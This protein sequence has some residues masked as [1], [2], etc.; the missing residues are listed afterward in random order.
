MSKKQSFEEA[1]NRLE[2]ISRELES[3]EVSLEDSLK[4][5]EEGM[6]LVSTCNEKLQAAETAIKK[7]TRHADGS[8]SV[9]DW[10]GDAES[11]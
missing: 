2:A 9:D 5:F 7:L 1:F 3:G 10:E 6:K 4:L 8:T 11:G